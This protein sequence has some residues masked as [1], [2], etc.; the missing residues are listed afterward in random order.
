MGLLKNKNDD[1]FNLYMIRQ[2]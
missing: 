2:W 1:S